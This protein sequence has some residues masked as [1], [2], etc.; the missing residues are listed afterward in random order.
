MTSASLQTNSKVPKPILETAKKLIPIIKANCDRIDSDRQ[1]PTDL[2]K[3]MNDAGLF[4]FMFLRF[5]VV[6][7]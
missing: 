7:S 3:I 6:Q 2:A 4:R 1:L 5:W